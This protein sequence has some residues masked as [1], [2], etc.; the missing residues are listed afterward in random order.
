MAS[1]PKRRA[2]ASAS[3]TATAPDPSSSSSAGEDEYVLPTQPQKKAKIAP[4]FN[5]A[6]ESNLKNEDSTFKFTWHPLIGPKKSCLH[7]SFKD[8]KP[9]AKLALFDLDGTIVR[10]KGGKTVSGAQVTPDV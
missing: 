6:R 3:A 1:R 2:A 4:I 10:P 5:L 8:P 9:S 7:G